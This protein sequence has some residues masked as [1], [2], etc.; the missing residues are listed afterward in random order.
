MRTEGL[1]P[2][3]TTADVAAAAGYSVQQVRDLEALGVIPPAPRTRSGYRQF[4]PEHVHSLCAYRDLAYA[5]RPVVACR[6][7]RQIRSA[8][9]DY[10]AAM[11]SELHTRLNREREHTLAARSALTSISSEETADVAPTEDDCMTITELAQALEVKAS[12]LRFWESVGLI[13]PQRVSTPAGSVRR[14]PGVA[15]RAPA[16]SLPFA[17]AATASPKYRRRSAQS[18]NS[19]ITPPHSPR[20]TPDSRPSPSAHSH[21]SAPERSW[22]IPSN[23]L[24]QRDCSPQRQQR[25]DPLQQGVP[26][27]PDN[28]SSN[29]GQGHT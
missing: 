26:I 21:Y 8:P 10:A 22:Q 29:C 5:V 6:T 20:S 4:S 27:R 7:M 23:S 24:A 3:M 15:I 1:S 17:R 25:P 16:S 11:I 13:T 2:T 12:T 19:R 28:A 18:V 9:S 14:Y